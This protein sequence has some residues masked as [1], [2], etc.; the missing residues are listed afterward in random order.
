MTRKQQIM[1][2]RLLPYA[3]VLFIGALI[4]AGVIIFAGKSRKVPA[5]TDTEPMQSGEADSTED[6]QG[7]IDL[8]TEGAVTETEPTNPPISAV[9]QVNVDKL[10][11][12]YYEA[13]INDN[14]EELNNIVDTDEPYNEADLV[15]ETQFISHYDNF[16]TYVIPGITD[17]YFVVYVKYDIFF[18]GIN[19]GA[20]SLNHFIV[21]KDEDGYYYIYNKEVSGEFQSYL[22]QTEQ[23]EIV[24]GLKEQVESELK[25]A[26][27]S[28]KDLELLISMLKG[29]KEETG[30]QT[31]IQ[32][33]DGG[34]TTEADTS[35]DAE[36]TAGEESESFETQEFTEDGNS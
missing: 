31:D 20:P 1:L 21:V 28:N 23:S 29:E 34:N 33:Y 36:D 27:D 30:S 4:V 11:D 14:A 24:M 6:E 10:I 35:S 25:A 15:D 13:K 17:N 32:D 12:R 19:T 22:E 2:R 7:I 18:N 16:R 3:A 26:C 5:E 9:D 8:D